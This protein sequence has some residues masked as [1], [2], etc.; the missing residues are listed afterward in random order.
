MQKS[1]IEKQIEKESF[2]TLIKNRE[3]RN[4]KIQR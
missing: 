4:G 1:N 2:N 3:K